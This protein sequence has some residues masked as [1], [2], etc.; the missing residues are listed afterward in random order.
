MYKRQDKDRHHLKDEVGAAAP[1]IDF[2][3][4]ADDAG[5]LPGELEIRVIEERQEQII[6]EDNEGPGVTESHV[7][8]LP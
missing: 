7:V 8:E 4:F 2:S 1:S 6:A 5:I 3:Q